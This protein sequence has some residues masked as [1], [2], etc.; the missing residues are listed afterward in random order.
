M[1]LGLSNFGPIVRETPPKED[2]ISWTMAYELAA[3]ILSYRNDP[4][5]LFLSFDLPPSLAETAIRCAK[6]F[7]L[8][9]DNLP[10]QWT[11]YLML[12]L[13]LVQG[14]HPSMPKE[15]IIARIELED[16]LMSIL[17]GSFRSI[18]WG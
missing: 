5:E 11:T 10:M 18:I 2:E 6:M 8:Q 1:A 17:Y 7:Y 4:K 3:E 12:C 9:C 13:V 15:E 14:R 16:I